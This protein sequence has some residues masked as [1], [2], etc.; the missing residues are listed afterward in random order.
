MAEADKTLQ[1][2]ILV[3]FYQ[4]SFKIKSTRRFVGLVDTPGIS[5]EYHTVTQLNVTSD[6]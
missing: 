5:P 2:G 6:R 4:P 1:P 3:K